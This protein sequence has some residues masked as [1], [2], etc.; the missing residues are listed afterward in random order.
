MSTLGVSTAIF[1]DNQVLLIKRNDFP[2]WGLPGGG[3][4][5]GES[6][7]QAAVRETREETGLEVKLTRQVGI[8]SRPKWRHGGDHGILFAATP[9]GGQLLT[10]TDETDDARYF[11]VTE[12][13]ADLLWHHYQRIMDAHRGA[14][15]ATWVQEA[16]WPFGEVTD[17]AEIQRLVK[18]GE[19]TIDELRAQLCGHGRPEK[20]RVELQ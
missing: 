12:L 5:D 15:G 4:D 20:E 17:L 19:V 6:I 11:D 16:V 3:V 10:M 8:Y 7:A 9:L 13:P 1:Q 2:V 18:Q 14:T